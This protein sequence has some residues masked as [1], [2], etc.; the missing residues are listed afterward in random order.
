M[1]YI[2]IMALIILCAVILYYVMPRQKRP[3]STIFDKKYFAHRGLHDNETDAPENSLKAF[4]K[5]VDSGFGVELDVQLT[6]DKELVVFHDD[7]LKRVCGIDGKIEDF[8]FDELQEF[9][10]CK[11][12]E[13][14]PLFSEV[15]KVI[16]AKVGI[17]VELK[18]YNNHNELGKKTNEVLSDYKGIYCI[19]SFHPLAVAWY[20]DNRPDIIR[21]QLSGNLNKGAS[22]KSLQYFLCHA[23]IY[24][25]YSRPDFISYDV[26]SRHD[27]SFLFN[28]KVLGSIPVA[29]TIKSQN[30]IDKSKN[31]FDVFIFEGFIPER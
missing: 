29:W 25:K 4:Q 1:K 16:D 8:T 28:T 21:G 9:K 24:N 26:N 15:L 22:K 17:I 27:I 20:K 30:D 13:R 10:I 14:I 3:K 2:L 12:E 7:T 19:E 31:L 18:P 23:L 6:K 11:S 5:A